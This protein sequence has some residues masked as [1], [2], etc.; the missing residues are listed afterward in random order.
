MALS[1]LDEVAAVVAIGFVV[2]Y[3][4]AT[5]A[6]GATAYFLPS[7]SFARLSAS[8]LQIAEL[9]QTITFSLERNESS[10]F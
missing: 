10:C 6:I 9:V 8:L 4:Q 5:Q 7:R 2:A 3:C 1:S